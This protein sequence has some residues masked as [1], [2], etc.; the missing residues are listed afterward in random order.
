MCVRGIPDLVLAIVFV[1]ITGLG[2]VAGVLALG[3]GAVGLLGKL[4]ADSVEEVDPGVED[5][6]RATGS[7]TSSCPD[8]APSCR[9]SS[10]CCPSRASCGPRA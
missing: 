5:A 10:R 6:L 3:V 8:R 2:A 1:V 7:R 9:S 4:V